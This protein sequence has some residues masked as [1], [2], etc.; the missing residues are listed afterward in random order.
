MAAVSST[1]TRA[2]IYKSFARG[3]NIG[4]VTAKGEC[5][6]NIADL[7]NKDF[8]KNIL[9]KFSWLKSCQDVQLGG[10][11]EFGLF[12]SVLNQFG[13]GL[14]IFIS[15]RNPSLVATFAVLS[16]GYLCCSY[17]EVKERTLMGF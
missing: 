13:A 16:C 15:K 1:S 10:K 17:Q 6:S 14:G 8:E 5:I 2:P 12:T 7:V 4:D 9:E 3:E 11:V